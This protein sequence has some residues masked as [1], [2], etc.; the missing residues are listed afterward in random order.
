M[1]DHPTLLGFSAILS[2]SFLALFTAMSSVVPPFQLTAMSFLIGGLL[3][4]VSW[5]RPGEMR[6]A[7]RQPF[8]VWLIGVGGLF[9]YHVL[10]FTALKLAPPAEAN[11]I[12]ALWP[13]LIVLL[14]TLLPGQHFKPRYMLGAL[15]GFSGVVLLVAGR[16]PLEFDAVYTLGYLAAFG[17]SLLWAGYSVL[18]R[19]VAEVPT[20]TVAGFCL[21]TAVLSFFCHLAFEP[22]VW[23]GT[24][25]AWLAVVLMGVGPVGLAFYAWDHGMKR[26][27]IRLLGALA[28]IG[29]ALAT[30]FL[31]LA[32]YAVPSPT[33]AV[34]C[35]M[36]IAGAMVASFPGWK[37]G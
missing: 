7:L 18:S 8:H 3:G 1:K 12:N 5:L 36:I 10:Y 37:K 25:Q 28:Y 26:G 19:C 20:S 4:A 24:I 35:A 33:L 14:S 21:V 15:I 9:G 16:G 34:S 27:D 30:L 32:G 6:R 23:P 13:L 29:P 17:C 31:I 22:T 11:L 2:W